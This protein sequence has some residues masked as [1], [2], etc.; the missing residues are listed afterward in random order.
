[1][2]MKVLSQN[3]AFKLSDLL[4]DGDWMVLYYAEWCG[5]CNT[6]KPEWE[7][8]ITKMK[9][10]NVNSTNVKIADVKSDF[11][12]ALKQKP[13]IPGFPTIK[14]YSNGKEVADFKDDR[15]AE[16]M[17]DFAKSNTKQP[18]VISVNATTV[19]PVPEVVQSVKEELPMVAIN[20][21]MPP[22]IDL[23][24]QKSNKHN[25]RTKKSKS[26]TKVS[27]A[28]HSAMK[29]STAKHSAM[30][31]SVKPLKMDN[32]LELPKEEEPAPAS[33]PT[34]TSAPAPAPIPAPAP[35]VAM[36]QAFINL[37]CNEIRKA[38]H[39]KSN[40]KCMFDYPGNKCV[41]KSLV[42]PNQHPEKSKAKSKAKT[43]AKTKTRSLVSR[44]Y[45]ATKKNNNANNVKKSTKEV[46]SK[47]VKSFGRI[48]N[49]AK[50]DAKILQN[51]TAKL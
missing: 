7:K 13:E 22:S 2:Y 32:L 17:V 34:P 6:M 23:L 29:H 38:K 27:A 20:A 47:L 39:C 11:I 18:D 10:P 36:Q 8:F 51:A 48:S 25:T 19:E 41:D 30:K 46:F 35:T 50:K 37:P 31:Q 33:A 1:M 42:I 44:K 4:K 15:I 43:K 12:S 9:D 26:N 49:E 28:K 45:K 14:M 40:P 21:D 16:K 24:S 3:D 5:H